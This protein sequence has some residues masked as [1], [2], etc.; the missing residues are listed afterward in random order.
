[1]GGTKLFRIH[2]HLSILDWIPKYLLPLVFHSCSV[3]SPA[4]KEV[5]IGPIIATN[6]DEV[7]S[8]LAIV[9]FFVYQLLYLSSS[10]HGSV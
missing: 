4:A 9:G 6:T 5:A 8:F 1:M 3:D 2:N 10:W 7:F